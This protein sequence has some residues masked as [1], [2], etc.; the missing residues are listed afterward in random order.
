MSLNITRINPHF[1]DVMPQE[2]KELVENGP[3]GN[4][5]SVGDLGSFKEL[6]EEHP[7]C[8]GCNLALAFR[9]IV[10]SLPNP[11]DTCVVGTTGCNSLAMSQL[12]L[13]NVHSLFGNQNAVATGLKRALALRFPDQV[14][15]VVVMA[16]DGATADIGLD[17]TMH[18]WFRQEKIT[19]VMFDN[20]LYA[21]TGGQESGMSV[22]GAVLNMA[23][24]GKKFEKVHMAELAITSGCAYVAVVSTA[25]PRQIGK[26]FQK[27]VLIAREV[28]PTYVQIH[29]PC[30]TNMKMKPH[31]G[32]LFAKERLKTDYAFRE[33]I[34]PEA[35]EYLASL[36]SASAEVAE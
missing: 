6:L 36:E 20:E 11:E 14:K 26:S 8:A 13:H 17:M 34:T 23:P 10:G 19:T 15:D 3:F 28:G 12:A 9:L 35:E 31:E 22:S 18:S 25:R 2:Y 29:T 32:I 16:G 30:P 7:L 21:N 4:P 1:E 33:H 5:K 24:T 27:A